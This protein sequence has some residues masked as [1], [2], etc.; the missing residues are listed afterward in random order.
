MMTRNQRRGAFAKDVLEQPLI[1]HTVMSMLSAKD[2]I[3]FASMSN[4]ARFKETTKDLAAEAR[5]I[6]NMRMFISSW[7]GYIDTCQQEF[8]ETI[9]DPWLYDNVVADH[10][11][12]LANRLKELC[13]YLRANWHIVLHTRVGVLE[14]AIR[15]LVN[16]MRDSLPDGEYSSIDAFVDDM[17]EG[18]IE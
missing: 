12:Y 8:L 4:D 10:N 15:L 13:V 11:A 5:F 1:A 14:Y 17:N 9:N 7:N 16:E 6:V 2:R 3:S 18:R